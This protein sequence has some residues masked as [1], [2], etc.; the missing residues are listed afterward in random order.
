LPEWSE[1]IASPDQ[2][3]HFGL[4]PEMVAP[5]NQSLGT[6]LDT[7]FAKVGSFYPKRENFRLTPEAKAKSTGKL[8]L[9]PRDFC[10]R[11]V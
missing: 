10:G 7:L 1:A 5:P 2:V 8:A 4:T 9:N 11:K 6:H 3:L